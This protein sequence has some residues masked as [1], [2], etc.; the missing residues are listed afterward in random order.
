MKINVV[1]ALIAFAIG[2]LA[3]YGFYAWNGAEQYQLLV[4]IGGGL[5][6]FLYF[7]GLVALSSDGHGTVGNI[8]VLSSV[9]LLITVISHS[10]FSFV[11][12]QTPTAYILINGILLLL[13][14]LISYA[15]MRALRN[16][17]TIT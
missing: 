3:G 10:V 15:V 1:F 7:G 12:M 2:A 8:R 11:N 17:S 5:T 9:F 14:V 16:S 4:A 13:F 6:I